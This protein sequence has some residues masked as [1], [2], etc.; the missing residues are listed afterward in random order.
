MSSGRDVNRFGGRSTYMATMSEHATI[1]PFPQMRAARSWQGGT[2]V[3]SQTHRG[4]V[5]RD[6]R[7]RSR[8]IITTHSRT[9]FALV[10]YFRRNFISFRPQATGCWFSFGLISNRVVLL[11]FIAVSASFFSCQRQR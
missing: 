3:R 11:P 9:C 8:A 4:F 7:Q 10:P 5:D 6:A 1:P 2:R